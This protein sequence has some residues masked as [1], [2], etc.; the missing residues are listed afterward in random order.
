VEG[1]RERKKLQTRRAL[2]HAAMRLAVDRGLHNVRVEDVAA[3]AGVSTRTFNNYFSGKNE[4]ICA[5]AVDHAR[6]IGDD[7]QARP[8][9]EPFWQAFTQ[10]VLAQYGT[11]D[12]P[13]P[14][15]TA[16]VR[17]VTSEPALIGEHPKAQA[18]LER[19]LAAAI[20]VR[21]E[22]D[23]D[24]LLPRIVAGAVTIAVDAALKRWLADP[25]TAMG[26]LVRSHLRS[27]AA[28]LIVPEPIVPETTVPE[29][30]RQE[31]TS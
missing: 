15:W 28:C 14:E 25:P 3:Q 18:E 23:A 13:D 21:L 2:G 27:V 6:Q 20:A 29:P 11:D 16:G 17:L 9:S 30:A 26:P 10:A 1:L 12:V 22:A 31:A 4:A 5:L 19:T 8:V 7:L 24:D